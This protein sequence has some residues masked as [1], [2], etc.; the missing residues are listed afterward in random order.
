MKQ[1][2]LTTSNFTDRNAER[3]SREIRLRQIN[4]RRKTS[5]QPPMKHPQYQNWGACQQS[6][7]AAIRTTRMTSASSTRPDQS[8]GTA[9]AEQTLP[10]NQSTEV[11]TRSH[12]ET[13][14]QHKSLCERSAEGI[15]FAKISRKPLQSPLEQTADALI[16]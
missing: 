13:C 16:I 6:S 11:H 5:C 2:V 1:Q 3:L 8:R 14:Q 12:A 7:R 4:R 10:S 15:C 9:A